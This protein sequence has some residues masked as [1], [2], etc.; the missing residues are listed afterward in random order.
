MS[1]T[2]EDSSRKRQRTDA[3]NGD[4]EQADTVTVFSDE[5]HWHSDGSLVIQVENTLFR[6]HRTM[7]ALNSEIFKDIQSCRNPSSWRNSKDTLYDPPYFSAMHSGTLSATLP[8][9]SSVL[10]LATKYRFLGYRTECLSIS[11]DISL[12]L[13]CAQAAAAV[14]NLARETNAYCLLPFAFLV[15]AD[16][17]G[18]DDKEFIIYRDLPLSYQDKAAALQGLHA[19]TCAQRD[20]MF[21][22]A[23]KT[24][25][26]DS[27]DCST[28][29]CRTEGLFKNFVRHSGYS[30]FFDYYEYDEWLEA[31]KALCKECFEYVR[32]T[33]RSGERYIFRR[34][35]EFFCIGEDWRELHKRQNLGSE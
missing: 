23:Y 30:F 28:G 1:A 31:E 24:P 14:I 35:P 4:A 15:C 3:S 34:L 19:L 10:R 29:E 21:P 8:V 26:R 20:R 11:I 22:F 27:T 9:L 7:M 13:G 5:K 2:Q 6:V 33:S 18:D 12:I 16:A 32:V 25:N 17:V